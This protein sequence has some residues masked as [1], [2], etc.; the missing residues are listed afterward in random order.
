MNWDLENPF[1][2]D[3]RVAAEDIDA[4]GHAN[5]TV[6]VR[7]L[8]RCAWEHSRSLGLGLDEYRELDRAMAVVRHEIDYLGAAYEGDELTM[9]TWIIHWDQK[10]RMTRHFQLIR[11]SDQATL[12]RARTTFACIELSTGKPRRMPPI[13]IENYGR[14]LTPGGA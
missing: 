8:E 5:N 9:A 12:L 13:F 7:W 11:D 3:I 4:L 1:T 6:Y 2:Y 10:L 14:G